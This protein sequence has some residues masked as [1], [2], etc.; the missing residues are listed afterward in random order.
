MQVVEEGFVSIEVREAA[1]V[2]ADV[3]GVG[4]SEVLGAGATVDEGTGAAASVDVA[5]IS[6]ASLDVAVSSSLTR[7]AAGS[8]L[9]EAARFVLASC[10]RTDPSSATTMTPLPGAPAH[11]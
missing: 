4:A 10:P 1:D 5:G 11:R 8:G 7:F 9:V 6:L 2:S 3:D